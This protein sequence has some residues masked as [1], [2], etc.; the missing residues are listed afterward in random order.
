MTTK[1]IAWILSILS[2]FAFWNPNAQPNNIPETRDY[3]GEVPDKYG[4]WPTEDFETGSI[5]PAVPDALEAWYSVFKTLDFASTTESLLI[6]HKGK[7]V[8]ERYAEGWDKDT[9]HFMASVTKSVTSALV[10]IAIGEGVIGGVDDKVVTYFPEAV[11]MPGWQEIKRDMTIEHLLTMTSGILTETYEEWNGFYSPD[12]T[13]SALYAFLLPQKTAPGKKFAYENAAPSI[14]LG[15]I[16]RATGRDVVEYAREKL[17]TPLGMTSVEWLRA[18]DGLPFGAFGISMTSRDMLRFGYLY[19]N[20]G[21]WDDKQI[22]PADYV[23]VTPPRSKARK[24]YGYMFWN[25]D[26]LPFDSSYE[27]NGAWGQQIEILPEY[28]MVIVRTARQSDFSIFLY[29]IQDKLD[30]MGLKFW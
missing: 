2:F 1:M 28:D 27:A 5:N 10:G 19:L 6:L 11:G 24:A 26:L 13:D 17:F 8:Y 4:V 22:I 21:R 12:Q 20:Q 9:P 23:A 7:I 16:A 3:V 29:Q 25:F 30:E 18:A 14:L 15:I